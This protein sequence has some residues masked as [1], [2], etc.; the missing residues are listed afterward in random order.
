MAAVDSQNARQQI[1]AAA[2]ELIAERGA[3]GASL[4]ELAGR[5]GLHNSTLFH[6]FPS[7]ESLAASARDAVA[8]R[9]LEWLAP[10]GADDPPQL[11]TLEAAL[12][13]WERHL[14]ANPAEARL[15]LDA[16]AGPGAMEPSASPPLARMRTLLE[17]WLAR[18]HAAGAISCP[19]P[20]AAVRCLL[21]AL[22]FR[23]APLLPAEGDPEADAGASAT[24][25]ARF[26]LAALRP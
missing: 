9:Q 21:G 6:Y 4:R 3:S 24:A 5:V 25:G 1:L 11:A 18:A 13:G 7:K 17:D 23:P 10:L 14:A 19:S 15:L 16:L 22:L 8:E 26:A 2:V 12:A 20:P